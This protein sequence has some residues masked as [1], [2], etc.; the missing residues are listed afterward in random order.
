[1]IESVSSGM[2]PM[3]SHQQ[4]NGASLSGDQKQLISDT[5][6]K[7]DANNL[8]E[9]DAKSIAAT[10]SDAGI[11][12]GKDMAEAMAA[13]GFDART[14]GEMA[15]AQLPPRGGSMGQPPEGM[16]NSGLNIDQEKMKEIFSLLPKSCKPLANQV[17][18]RQTPQ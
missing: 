16:N 4:T 7:F 11:R 6:S 15:G 8:T 17:E 18:K 1:M 2:M 3:P 5:L 10:F 13:S 12:P 9:S 14:V